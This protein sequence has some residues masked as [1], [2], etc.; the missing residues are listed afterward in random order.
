MRRGRARRKHGE[1][2][3]FKGNLG[4]DR[5]EGRGGKGEMTAEP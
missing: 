5:C 1:N 2:N 4:G 3:D